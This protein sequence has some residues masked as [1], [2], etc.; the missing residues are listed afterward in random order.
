MVKAQT[1]NIVVLAH[2]SFVCPS[3]WFL[4]GEFQLPEFLHEENP[5]GPS[6]WGSQ[7]ALVKYRI[8][9]LWNR[10]TVSSS[11][12]SFQ[13]SLFV[14]FVGILM[15]SM[16]EGSKNNTQKSA[17]REI[18]MNKRQKAACPIVH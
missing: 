14:C 16:G 9:F 5:V 18:N 3:V 13:K 8:P 6:V 10:N 12:N 11:K 17:E 15:S 7:G 2:C 4:R 1:V